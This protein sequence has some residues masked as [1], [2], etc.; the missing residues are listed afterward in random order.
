MALSSSASRI[1]VVGM[2]RILAEDAA[3]FAWR[4]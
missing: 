4:V 2:R 1:V 3:G